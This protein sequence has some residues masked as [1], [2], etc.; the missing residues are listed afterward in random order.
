MLHD[1]NFMWGVLGGSLV[2]AA[3]VYSAIAM[4]RRRR[5]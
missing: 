3:L 4:E 1:P 5:D 2:T